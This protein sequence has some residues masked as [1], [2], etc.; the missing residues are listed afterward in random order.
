VTVTSFIVTCA[1]RQKNRVFLTR[2]DSAVCAS[3]KASLDG[4]VADYVLSATR[5][6]HAIDKPSMVRR[7]AETARVVS[8]HEAEQTPKGGSN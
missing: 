2:M 3:C 7:M 6:A 1:C 5:A 4:P 8:E